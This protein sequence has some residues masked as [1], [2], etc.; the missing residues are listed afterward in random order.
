MF[1]VVRENRRNK[2]DN[3]SMQRR[4]S[5]ELFVLL[6]CDSISL[7]NLFPVFEDDIL[8]SSSRV[9]MSISIF[10]SHTSHPREYLMRNH[11]MWKLS[12]Y[13][14]ILAVSYAMSNI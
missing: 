4:F 11:G 6:G 13:M 3:K 14:Y 2:W 12:Q 10:I 9:K 1:S 7:D 8:V 5:F